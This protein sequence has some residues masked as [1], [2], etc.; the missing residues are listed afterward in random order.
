MLARL[1]AGQLERL[2]F[3][4]SELT[5]PEVRGDRR[6]PRARRRQEARQPGPLLPRRHAAGGVPAQARL[7]PR[8]GRPVSSST[9]AAASSADT[10]ASRASPSASGAGSGSVGEPLYVLAKDAATGRVTVGPRAEL[11]TRSSSYAT[12]ASRARASALTGEAALPLA[13]R[14][15][16][17]SKA[18]PPRASTPTCVS[19][20][21]RRSRGSPPGRPPSCAGVEQCHRLRHDERAVALEPRR[22]ELITPVGRAWQAVF[23]M[24]LGG[25]ADRLDLGFDQLDDLQ[26]AVERLLAEGARR[27]ARPARHSSWRTG[28]ATRI[29]PLRDWS[30]RRSQGPP[31][32]RA[33]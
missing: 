16:A 10:P 14:R 20:S 4:L 31:P 17:K 13:G 1:G 23:R 22:I 6:A 29:G 30:R 28:V 2:W 33:S 9:A 12:L 18:S 24:V 32:R 25:V 27:D 26:L 8:R 5:K 7:G 11:A 19:G 15:P 21:R 3:P